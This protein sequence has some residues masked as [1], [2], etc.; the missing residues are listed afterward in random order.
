MWAVLLPYLQKYS[1]AKK[2]DIIK[3]L[4]DNISDKQLYNYIDELKTVNWIKAKGMKGRIKKADI[5]ADLI[6]W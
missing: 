6:C 3:L 4:G 5:K 2:S 1:K